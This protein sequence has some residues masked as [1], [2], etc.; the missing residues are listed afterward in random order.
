[1]HR[2]IQRVI[3]DGTRA[4]EVLTGIRKL[5]RK[6]TPKRE[7]LDINELIREVI[8]LTRSE[9]H[10][11]NISLQLHLIADISAV[12]A[13]RVQL[14]QVLMNLILNAIDAMSSIEESSGELSITTIDESDHIRVEVQDTGPGIAQE[15]AERVFMPFQTS[16]AGGMGMGLSICRTIVE[17]HGG[18]LRVVPHDGP[19]A[20]FDFTLQKNG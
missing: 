4:G 2:S 8:V 13:D 17:D 20:R 3:R 9:L 10:K 7:Q 18:R 19:G 14:Q 12:L 11:N 6:E 1:V 15:D 5:F 16:K